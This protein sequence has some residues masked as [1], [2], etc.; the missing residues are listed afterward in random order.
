L[1]NNYEDDASRKANE[2]LKDLNELTD[3]I[4]N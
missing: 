4:I 2:E 1:Y 3:K